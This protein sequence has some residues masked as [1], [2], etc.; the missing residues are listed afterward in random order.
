VNQ[1]VSELEQ[2]LAELQAQIDQLTLSLHLWRENQDRLQPTEDRLSELTERASDILEQWSSSGA[3]HARAIGELETR[4]HDLSSLEARMQQNAA[5]RVRELERGIEHEWTAL[6]EIHEMPARQLTEQA[7]NLT[8]VAVTAAASAQRGFDRA[9]ARLATIETDLHHRMSELTQE[10]RAVVTELRASRGAP[11]LA[12]PA[13]TSWPLEGVMRLHNEL[14]SVDAPADEP[15]TATPAAERPQPKED[16]EDPDIPT[17]RFE[18]DEPISGAPLRLL[19]AAASSL[20]DRIQTLEQAINDGQTSI[21]ENSEL[22]MRTWRIALAVVLAGVLVS[23]G[24]LWTMQQQVQV[25]AARA[26]EAEQ[27]A[28]QATDAANKQVT[29]ARAD[30]AQQIAEARDAAQK[31]RIVSEVVASMDTVRYMLSGGDGKEQLSAQLLWSRSH[32][33]V[34]S[35]SRLPPP[36]AGSTY[37]LWLSTATGPV[38][39]GAFVPDSAGR[40]TVATDPPASVSRVVGAFVT[41]EPAG[42]RAKPSGTTLLAR[43]QTPAPAVPPDEQVR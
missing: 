7:A 22:T 33:F 21:R 19:P 32:G 35:G 1:Q 12:A 23:G 37:Q 16:E 3:R 39:A 29:T 8:E 41:V 10:L 36:P 17:A 28:R 43:I 15:A 40:V 24:L 26:S 2:R 11:Q 5:E 14:R 30:A 20:S 6:R 13:P 42:G 34:F 38:S 31:A 25:S 9:E 4:L 27:Q 18:P